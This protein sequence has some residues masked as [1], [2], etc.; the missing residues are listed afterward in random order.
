MIEQFFIRDSIPKAV[1]QFLPYTSP[2]KSCDAIFSLKYFHMRVATQ[3]FPY[4]FPYNS[5]DAFLLK[6][7]FMKFVTLFFLKDFLIKK[8]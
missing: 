2:Y 1:T 5:C 3:F 7:F 6:D 4:T 8:L